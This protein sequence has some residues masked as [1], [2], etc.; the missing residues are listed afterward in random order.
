[1]SADISVKLTEWSE[2][3]FEGIYLETELQRSL[4]CKLTKSGILEIIELKKGVRIKSNSHVGCVFL[5]D[6]QIEIMPKLRG[7]PLITL[8]Q[9]AY[10]LRKLKLFHKADF[11]IERLNFFDLIIYTLYSYV[12]NLLNR[13]TVKGYTLFE[14]ELACIKGRIDITRIAGSGGIIA[15]TLP[16]RYYERNENTLL[17]Q[18]LLAGVRLAITLAADMNLRCNMRKMCERLSL[19]AK[20]IVLNQQVLLMARRSIT[21]LNDNY[22]P[23]LELIKILYEAHSVRLENGEIKRVSLPGF[24]FDMNLFFESLVSKLLQSIS[25]QYS[26]VDQYRIGALFNYEPRYNPHNKRSPTPRPDFALIKNGVV[27]QLLDAKYRDLWNNSLPRD[28]LYQLAIYAASGIGNHTA[29][30]LYPAMNEIPSLQQINI[31]NPLTQEYMAKIFIKPIN[32][33]KIAHFIEN[34]K[35]D[36]M[37]H[38]FT[39]IILCK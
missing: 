39:D 33:V 1:M 2:Q 16:C 17:N 18:V 28:M 13:R 21:R 34:E 6:I 26:I 3:L 7:M 10:G 12:D 8:L 25:D 29:T 23:V 15:A 35:I 27:M 14:Q 22:K 32:L 11:D 9:Y 5:G 30:I 19:L 4:A 31:T 37:S 20:D 38:Y 36:H 24:F